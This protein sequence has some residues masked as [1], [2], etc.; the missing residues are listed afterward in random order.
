MKALIL[1]LTLL[2]TI[3]YSTVSYAAESLVVVVNKNNPINEMNRSE[4]IDLFLGKYVAFPDGSKA[5]PI[6][7]SG[8]NEIKKD[9]YQQLVGMSLSRINAYWARIRFSGR[10]RN[11]IEQDSEHEVL[12][13]LNNDISTISYIRRSLVTENVKVVFELH[14]D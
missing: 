1:I 10:Q 2:N 7:L 8:D 12:T 4:V 13:L 14:E 5:T 11:A 9:F 6:E 3:L